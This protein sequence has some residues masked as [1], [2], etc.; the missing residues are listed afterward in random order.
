MRSNKSIDYS[1]P[2]IGDDEVMIRLI[3]S[4]LYDDEAT[5]QVSIDAFVIERI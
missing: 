2:A 4:P 5:G 1:A 3:C